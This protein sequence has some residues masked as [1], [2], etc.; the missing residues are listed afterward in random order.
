MLA[1]QGLLTGDFPDSPA[2]GLATG[3]LNRLPLS[4]GPGHALSLRQISQKHRCPGAAAP[5]GMEAVGF[6]TDCISGS[7]HRRLPRA[8]EP[9]SPFWKTVLGSPRCADRRLLAFW[10]IL[11]KNEGWV[12]QSSYSSKPRVSRKSP[13]PIPSAPGGH[14]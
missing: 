11:R 9:Q 8:K 5:R 14:N 12:E 13:S 1:S 4:E 3:A 6:Q 10:H 2:G 7:L